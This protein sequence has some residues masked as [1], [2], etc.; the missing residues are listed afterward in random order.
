MQLNRL[1]FLLLLTIPIPDLMGQGNDP[2]INFDKPALVYLRPASSATRIKPALPIANILAH[3]RRFD[4]TMLGITKSPQHYYSVVVFNN[5]IENELESFFRTTMDTMIEPDPVELHCFIKKLI[6]SDH[7]FVNN[8]NEEEK[9]ASKKFDTGEKSGL[10]MTL[11]FYAKV[12]H[13]FLALCRFDTTL[14][15]VR[16]IGKAGHWYLSEALSASL[17]K[18]E[19]INWKK[20][21]TQ[22]KKLN[23]AEIEKHYQQRVKAPILETEPSKGIYLS[24]A[25]FKNNKVLNRNFKVEHSKKGDF[26]YLINEKG[27]DVLF[28]DLW[29]YSDGK[30]AYI[31]SANNYFKLYR[32]GRSFRIY[33]AKD[34]ASRK[35][36]RMNAGLLDL[37]NPNS[38]YTGGK[39]STE[40]FLIKTCL[41]LDLETG[42]LY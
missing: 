12:Q 13:D 34:L 16:E 21:S 5:G 17:R 42:E 32:S 10:I 28:T 4:T 9:L 29:G 19:H 40:Y 14:V 18:L 6:L 7:I 31:Y 26:L 41:Q 25:D 33:G 11:E 1:L 37:I 20:I 23:Y 3:D 27:E 24:F 22:G 35:N 38:N 30:D 2:K 36:L 15:G 8:K 39:R